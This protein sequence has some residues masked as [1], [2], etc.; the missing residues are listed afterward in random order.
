MSL[1]QSVRLMSNASGVG[2]H[3]HL[4]LKALYCVISHTSP[5][6][7]QSDTIVMS[8]K[9]LSFFGWQHACQLAALWDPGLSFRK[10]TCVN[11]LILVSRWS[12]S[13]SHLQ[14]STQT[15]GRTLWCNSGVPLSVVM[16]RTRTRHENLVNRNLKL[17]YEKYVSSFNRSVYVVIQFQWMEQIRLLSIAV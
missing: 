15:N 4:N 14:M 12:W 17:R 1:N 13:W 6:H 7:L 5:Q 2:V 16:Q 11:D 9:E 3:L 10:M 8:K